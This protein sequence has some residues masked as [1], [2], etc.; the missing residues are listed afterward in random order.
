MASILDDIYNTEST[1]IP[2][3]TSVLS[4]GDQTSAAIPTL[5]KSSGVQSSVLDDIYTE[6]E[7][8]F[9]SQSD[10]QIRTNP[11]V[12]EAAMRFVRDRLGQTD[13][14]EEEAIDEFIEHFREFSVNELTAGGDYNYVSAAANDANAL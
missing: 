5:V 9:A 11:A 12:R 2:S 3:K 4:S 7:E 8:I 14:T 10:K 13:M 1:V 6:K